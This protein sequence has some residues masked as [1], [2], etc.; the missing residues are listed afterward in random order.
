[1]RTVISSLSENQ[2]NDSASKRQRRVKST[3]LPLEFWVFGSRV[4]S[5]ILLLPRVLEKRDRRKRGGLHTNLVPF[6][7]V[8]LP[9]QLAVSGRTSPAERFELITP[10]FGMLG[11]EPS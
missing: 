5:R 8:V 9:P 7:L 4:P 2:K 1:M 11:V 10:N 6:L 3:K